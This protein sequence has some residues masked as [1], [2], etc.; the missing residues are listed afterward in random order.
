ML[1]GF[2]KFILTFIFSVIIFVATVLTLQFS[3]SIIL[4]I[5][6]CTILFLTAFISMRTNLKKGIY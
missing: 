5:M 1:K 6:M 2:I 3:A 4:K